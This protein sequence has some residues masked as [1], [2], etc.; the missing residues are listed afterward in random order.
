MKYNYFKNQ[1]LKWHLTNKKEFDWR[2]TDEPYKILLSEILLH[3]TDV[4][5][6]EK[7]YPK[8]IKKYPTIYH[9]YNSDIISLEEMFKG[10]GLFYRANRLKKISQNIVENFNGEIPNTKEKLM[11]LLGVG[12]YISNA[13]LC[14]AFKKRVPI[15]DTN[16]IRIY[17]RIFKL[18]SKKNRPR[19]DKIVWEF[20]WKMLPK[21]SYIEYNY[22]LLDFSSDVCR[23]RN[24]L[25]KICVMRNICE[26]W[27]KGEKNEG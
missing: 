1:I 17:N 5:K 16:I 2:N 14:F 25:C 20:A 19:N 9:I 13:V 21:E 12:S 3:K 15:V 26:N 6:V 27:K 10:I 7:V 24:P 23:A 22:A 4:K 8:F 18:E 11:S